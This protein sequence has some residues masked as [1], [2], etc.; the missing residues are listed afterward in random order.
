MNRLRYAYRNR[1][2]TTPSACEWA[3]QR[4]GWHGMVWYSMVWYGMAW[5]WMGYGMDRWMN[6]WLTNWMDMDV[7]L[8]VAVDRMDRLMLF[9]GFMF[10]QIGRRHCIK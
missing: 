1:R 2:P 10:I 7:G 3:Q 6:D 8:C 4:M 9:G 5:D